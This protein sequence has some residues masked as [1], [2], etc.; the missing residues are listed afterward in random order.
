ML[1]CIALQSH[2]NPYDK[3]RFAVIA[4]GVILDSPL[5]G[6]AVVNALYTLVDQYQVEII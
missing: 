2:P 4:H 5:I 6:K 1:L 3:R